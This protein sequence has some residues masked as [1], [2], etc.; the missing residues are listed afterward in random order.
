MGAMPPHASRPRGTGL[1]LLA[2]SQ[3]FFLRENLK[4]R[5]V[6][7]RLALLFRDAGRYKADLK[8]TLEA[9]RKLRG[10]RERGAR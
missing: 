7:A 4:L 10:D 5:L 8:A 6:G 2:P 3:A 1:A 9:L